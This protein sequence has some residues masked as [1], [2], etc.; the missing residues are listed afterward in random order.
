MYD[1][2]PKVP[3][4]I[5]LAAALA[6]GTATPEEC[7]LAAKCLRDLHDQVV[8]LTRQPE[9]SVPIFSR[10]ECPFNYCD[11][12]EQYAACQTKCRHASDPIPCPHCG[13]ETKPG[14]GICT[15]CALLGRDES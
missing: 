4:H 8:L 1:E 10:P 6:L 2:P 7:R 13:T 9:P 12:R 11:Q 15:D 3:D 5:K 14:C